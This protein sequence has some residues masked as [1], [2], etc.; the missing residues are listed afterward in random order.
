MITMPLALVA[1]H[2]ASALV[3]FDHG[4]EAGAQFLDLVESITVTEG[5]EDVLPVITMRP[6]AR[7]QY[8]FD[9]I[10]RALT[11]ALELRTAALSAPVPPPT[12]VAAAASAAKPISSPL[13]R[14]VSGPALPG[15]RR[16][17]EA[18]SAPAL[19][20]LNTPAALLPMIELAIELGGRAK[21]R[22]RPLPR[23]ALMLAM[24][25]RGLWRGLSKPQ[26]NAR[27]DSAIAGGWLPHANGASIIT[28]LMKLH[29]DALV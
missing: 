18:V 10:T 7:T 3:T 2:H 20:L 1:I 25:Y 11:Y 8:V 13:P 29:R 23:R 5:D 9:T 27:I 12:P 6:I 16:S 4:P 17:F 19:P 24:E 21:H 14:I 26:L 28:P 15:C 22:G